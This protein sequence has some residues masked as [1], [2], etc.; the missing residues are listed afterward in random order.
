MTECEKINDGLL[1]A[2]DGLLDEKSDDLPV[3]EIV[4]GTDLPQ[5]LDDE[6]N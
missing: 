3:I 6:S 1:Q 5:A 2:G 4:E